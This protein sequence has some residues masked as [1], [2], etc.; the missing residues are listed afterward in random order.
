[1]KKVLITGAA[2]YI[3]SHAT[4]AL[5]KQGYEVLALD[6]FSRGARQALE[7]IKSEGDL[8]VF[9]ADLLEAE[10][11]KKILEENKPDMVF[12]FGALCSV[13]E[14]MS[15]PELY[16]ENNFL[17][18][19]N[20]LE[21]MRLAKT[22]KLIFSSTCAVYDKSEN[23]PINE[24]CPTG[25]ISPYAESKLATEKMIKWFGRAHNLKSVIFR[26]FNVCGA[27]S[28]GVIGDS[29]RPSLLLM[30]NAIR[31]IMGLD[32][33]KYTC[34]GVETPDG[35]PIRDYI[36]V[37]D[38]VEAHMAAADYLNQGGA[39]DLFNLGNGRGYSVKEVIN[40]V[41]KYFDKKLPEQTGQIR[42]GEMAQIYADAGKAQRILKW[43]ARKSLEDSITSLAFWY[44]KNP[45]GFDF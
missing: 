7:V 42:Q 35:T 10:K 1:M 6:N 8:R 20:L 31:G 26:Y 19:L 12:H 37:E 25:P 21:A 4:R 18:T 28:D 16:F 27:A 40:A 3:G 9:E 22:E 29:K 36:D 41:E 38:L 44:K 11:I 2:G 14:S 34:S 33:F 32:D 30:Q 13:D 45:N 39:S 43:Q 23:L 15:Q 17:G 24:D 5:L